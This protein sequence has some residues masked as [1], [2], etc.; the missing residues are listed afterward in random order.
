MLVYGDG[1]GEGPDPEAVASKTGFQPQRHQQDRFCPVQ[2]IEAD[3]ITDELDHLAHSERQFRTDLQ[4]GP[5][6]ERFGD[7]CH[8]LGSGRSSDA[9]M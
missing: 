7:Q 8:A 2:S 9:W 5:R 1:I 6:K 3:G 4:A